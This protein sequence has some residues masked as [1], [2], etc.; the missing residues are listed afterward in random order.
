MKTA[1]LPDP[2]AMS[3]DQRAAEITTILASGLL[4]MCMAQNERSSAAPRDSTFQL[5]FS[6]KQRVHTTP[7]QQELQ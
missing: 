4:R 5:G 7:Y 2:D 3:A 1:N 6:A